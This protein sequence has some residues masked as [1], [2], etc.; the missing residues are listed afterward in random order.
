MREFTVPGEG[1]TVA[2][3]TTLAFINPPAA[4]NVNVDD[5][6]VSPSALIGKK[7]PRV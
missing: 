2:G 4:P 3:A 5:M 6:P 1:L 7:R